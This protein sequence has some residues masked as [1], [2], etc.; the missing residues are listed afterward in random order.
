MKSKSLLLYEDMQLANS[1]MKLK[2]DA[3]SMFKD[4][5]QDSHPIL[6]VMMRGT[7]S[8]YMTNFRVY[9]GVHMKRGASTWTTADN[10]GTAAYER[11]VLLNHSSYD[12]KPIGRVKGFKYHQLK[13]GNDFRLDFKNPVIGEGTEDLGSGFITLKTHITDPEAIGGILRGEYQ[14]VSTAQSANELYCSICGSSFLDWDACCG[15]WPGKVY[16]IEVG[17]PEDGKKKRKTVTM[18]CF[19]ITGPLIYREVSYVNVPAQ[20]NAGNIEFKFIENDSNDGYILNT[21][22]DSVH[23]ES[24]TLCDTEGNRTELLNKEEEKMSTPTGEKKTIVAV[25][26]DVETELTKKVLAGVEDDDKAGTS[27][28]NVKSSDGDNTEVS[29]PDDDKNSKAESANG[30]D[31]KSQTDVE[32]TEDNFP[33]ANVARSLG[34]CM[35]TESSDELNSKMFDGE[36]K[37]FVTGED[38]EKDEVTSHTHRILLQKEEDGLVTGYTYSVD[39][40]GPMHMHYFEGNVEDNGTVEGKTRD[41]QL[42][43]WFKTED[44][45]R[46]GPNHQH[47]FKLEAGIDGEVWLV[48]DADEVQGLVKALDEAKDLTE[49]QQTAFD[50]KEFC[51]PNKVFPV[52]DL[53]HAT[54]ATS[55]LPRFKGSAET[56]VR[57]VAGIKRKADALKPG[58]KKVKDDETQVKSEVKVEDHS[59]EFKAKLY[60][61]EQKATQLEGKLSDKAEEIKLLTDEQARMSAK[62]SEVLANQ[63]ALVRFILDKDDTVLVE[64]PEKWEELVK[65]YA[66]RSHDSLQ[67][68]LKD[69]LPELNRFMMD[70]REGLKRR[71]ILTEKPR[72]EKSKV[73]KHIDA[74]NTRG[75]RVKVMVTGPRKG[76]VSDLDEDLS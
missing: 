55:L 58:D 35:L 41:A 19:A 29:T 50:T 37:M 63:L 54:A 73:K 52:P 47:A 60:D 25:N 45:N 76:K 12:G 43:R 27:N 75:R 2:P 69:L 51:G 28:D 61:S 6:E 33:L 56:K 53:D 7:C 20:P 64:S 24:V 14:T 5:L 40:H 67:D 38:S 31:D 17:K 8:G 42:F 32:L 44:G 30:T 15:H 34:T 16:E 62:V 26:L 65:A 72:E 22:C 59:D 9:P 36:T 71:L 66:G 21:C 48:P 10:G 49:E 57:I 46:S 4:S 13:K 3:L 11:P 74:T 1:E 23:Y 68:G 70:S 18:L 39:G